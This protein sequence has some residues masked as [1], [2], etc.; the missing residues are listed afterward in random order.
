MPRGVADADAGDLNHADAL[1]FNPRVPVNLSNQ[2]AKRMPRATPWE[3]PCS[4][5][6]QS[7]ESTV[8][9]G[10]V[11]RWRRWRRPAGCMQT[12]RYMQWYCE[13]ERPAVMV[14]YQ[15][16]SQLRVR[17][18]WEAV[19]RPNF[20]GLNWLRR[21]RAQP[22][23]HLPPTFKTA[24]PTMIDSRAVMSLAIENAVCRL[25]RV[26]IMSLN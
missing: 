2:V 17:P 10:S 19:E 25:S 14:P 11:R 4:L 8:C 9:A 20:W 13:F 3:S 1:H 24:P 23:S 22:P 6:C 18:D 21:D 26:A 15:M 12:G 7:I 5:P 16:L